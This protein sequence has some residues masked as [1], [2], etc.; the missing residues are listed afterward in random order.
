MVRSEELTHEAIVNHLMADDYYFSAGQEAF[1][2]C[3]PQGI[4]L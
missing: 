2:R 4:S 3:R 1:S